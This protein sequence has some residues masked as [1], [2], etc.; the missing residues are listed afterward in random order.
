MVSN[1]ELECQAQSRVSL[2]DLGDRAILDLLA[3][4]REL[5]EKDKEIERL[6]QMA[7]GAVALREKEMAERNAR[8]RAERERN[9]R[10]AWLAECYRQTGADP[11][12]DEDWR[13]APLAV[14]A[15]KQHRA[16]YDDACDEIAQ[17]ARRAERA[18]RELEEAREALLWYAYHAFDQDDP[19]EIRAAYDAAARESAAK[20]QP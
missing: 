4:R 11:D 3:A 12:G 6:E 7:T 1:E 14:A 16:D 19:P 10:N 5:E 18:E 15:V 9:E 20:E 17:V 8:E 13:L 2:G